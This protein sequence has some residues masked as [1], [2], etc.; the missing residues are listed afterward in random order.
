MYVVFALR[1]EKAVK[2]VNTLSK[3]LGLWYNLISIKM[4]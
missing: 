4:F 1:E 3:N 2:M